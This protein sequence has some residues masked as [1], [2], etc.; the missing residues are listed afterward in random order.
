M[1]LAP[2]LED[3]RWRLAVAAATGGPDARALAE[4][5]G[6]PLESAVRLT[7]LKV[8]HDA[9]DE[10][11]RDLAPGSVELRLNGLD[12]EFVVTPPGERR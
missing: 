3:F 10:V 1:D 2:Y 11:T 9:M 8:L 12:A 5:L 6:P 4:R 7:V